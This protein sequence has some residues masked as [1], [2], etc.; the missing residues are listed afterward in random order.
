MTREAQV[1]QETETEAVEAAPSPGRII[2]ASPTTLAPT[3]TGTLTGAETRNDDDSDDDDVPGVGRAPSGAGAGSTAGPRAP[4]S[5][6]AGPPGT[7]S[8]AARRPSWGSSPGRWPWS[9]GRNIE[10]QTEVCE[11]FTI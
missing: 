4:G 9:G 7:G 10:L 2:T 1:L 6:S 11:D 3:L 8:W 5:P